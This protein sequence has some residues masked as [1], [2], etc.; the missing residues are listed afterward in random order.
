MRVRGFSYIWNWLIII[1]GF[2][3]HERKWS[4]LE[5][6]ERERAKKKNS[7]TLGVCQSFTCFERPH[8][9][10]DN[11]QFPLYEMWWVAM[12]MA[13]ENALEHFQ[14]LCLI[15]FVCYRKRKMEVFQCLR[16][17]QWTCI[18]KLI[19]SLPQI[20]NV[21]TYTDS[22]ETEPCIYYTIS[23]APIILSLYIVCMFAFSF[24]LPQSMR[25]WMV[26][27]SIIFSLSFFSF[28]FNMH[29]TVIL[30]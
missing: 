29:H 20:L 25:L 6:R 5:A 17:M 2:P 7:F 16:S 23:F 30:T 8:S 24:F 9:E 14:I 21:Y 26:S 18:S 19:F 1:I 3:L 10:W 13:V 28:M 12:M 15:F 4:K 11:I 27:I 22:L